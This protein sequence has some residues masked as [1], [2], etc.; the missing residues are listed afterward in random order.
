MPPSTAAFALRLVAAL[1]AWHD[2]VHG[3]ALAYFAG[4]LRRHGG[5]EVRLR[6]ALV[7]DHL[8]QQGFG[9]PPEAL[10]LEAADRADLLLYAPGPERRPVAIIETKRSGFGDLLTTRQAKGETPPEQLARYVQL[11]GLYLG[12]LTNGVQWYFFDLATSLQPCAALNLLDL[13][14]LLDGVTNEADAAAALAQRPELANALVVAQALLAAEK[15]QAVAHY[16][17]ELADSALPWH[18]IHQGDPTHASRKPRA[19]FITAYHYPRYRYWP[20]S[21]G[22]NRAGCG[23][24]WRRYWLR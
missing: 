16:Q 8:L 19:E 11:R 9:Y 1:H 10:E 15:W 2:P 17:Q 22:G 21:S 18:E 3:P 6:A 4:D 23:V 20:Y 13:A 12:A 5:D 7:R 24:I 14:L